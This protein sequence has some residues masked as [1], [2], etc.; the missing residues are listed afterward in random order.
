M[1]IETLETVT[2]TMSNV[3]G[4]DPITVHLENYAP[5]KGGITIE[6]YGEVWS[7][8][9]P[10]MSGRRIE[11]FFVDCDEHYLAGKLSSISSE[12]NDFERFT[13]IVKEKLLMIRRYNEIDKREARELF[14]EIPERFESHS[15][16]VHFSNLLCRVIGYEWWYAV[17]SK[18]NHN[19]EYLTKLITTVQSGL[20]QHFQMEVHAHG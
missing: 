14:D 10:A 19:Y 7:S 18:P 8:K 5:G 9:W 1:K 13:D 17:P 6:C 11:Q 12:V 20:K 3:D 2:L 4:M 15:H 16:C